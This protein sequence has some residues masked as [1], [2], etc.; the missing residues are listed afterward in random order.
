MYTGYF[1]SDI[2]SPA[3]LK[4]QPTIHFQSYRGYFK[5]RIVVKEIELKNKFQLFENIQ[6]YKSY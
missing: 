3:E 6:Q 1:T 2:M 5:Y 4:T